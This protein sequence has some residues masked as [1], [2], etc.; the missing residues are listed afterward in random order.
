MR[1][2]APVSKYLKKPSL[3]AMFHSDIQ[4]CP[5]PGPHVHRKILWQQLSSLVLISLPA[6]V[7]K[8]PQ[9]PYW[10]QHC[11]LNFPS[12]PALAP[13]NL[14]NLSGGNAAYTQRKRCLAATAPQPRQRPP[15]AQ[16]G[17]GERREKEGGGGSGGK[18][19]ERGR[20]AARED[21]A[22][23]LGNAYF[24]KLLED[25]FIVP[26][27]WEKLFFDLVEQVV[28]SSSLKLGSALC[29]AERG[30]KTPAWKL[31]VNG[32]RSALQ[33]ALASSSGDTVEENMRGLS[34]RESRLA[35]IS[36]AVEFEN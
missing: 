29:S 22:R 11:W 32:N 36:D 26:D 18:A 12:L 27:T 24:Q 21:M 6:L 8:I 7:S 34:S 1:L 5:C 13:E 17:R 3:E 15:C 20:V 23:Q 33:R 9:H 2:P 25:A 19:E 35:H 31:R 10:R 14:E 16:G 28:L 30:P 4:K